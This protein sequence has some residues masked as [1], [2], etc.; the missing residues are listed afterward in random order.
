MS[1]TAYAAKAIGALLSFATSYIE[2]ITVVSHRAKAYPFRR[3]SILFQPHLS[4]NEG[5]SG[6]AA[7]YRPRVRSVYYERV[8]DHSPEGH[9]MFSALWGGLKGGGIAWLQFFLMLGYS[10]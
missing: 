8:Y 4:S 10:A 2:P 5:G 9:L 1:R 6:G 7:G 3:P